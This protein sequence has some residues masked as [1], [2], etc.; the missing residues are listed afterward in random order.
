M[1]SSNNPAPQPSRA[2]V[3]TAVGFGQM[4]AWG[5]SYYLL[6]IIARPMAAGLGLNPVWIYAAFSAALLV[7][8]L[9]G[10]WVGA[11]IDRHGGGKVLLF[12]NAVFAAGLTTLAVSQ[13]PVSMIAGWLLIGAAMPMGLY[14]AAFSTL[15]SL[16]RL[17]ARRS[18][19]GV[20]LIGGFA[21]SVSWP[22]TAALDAHF[23]WRVACAV[24]AVLHLTVGM[25]IHAFLV[26]RVKPVAIHPDATE[27]VQ[28]VAAPSNTTLW[29]LA[30]TF[31]CNGFIFAAMAAHL[32]RVLQ[33]AGCTPTAAVAAAAL[34]GVSQVVARL[35]DAGF[36]HRVHP[37]I[38]GRIAVSLHPLGAFLL[39]VFG[40]PVAVVFTALHGAS[41]GL[42]TIVKGTLPL[43]LF[44]SAGFGR[45]AGLL[46]APSRVVQALAPIAFGLML[47]SWGAHVLWISGAIGCVGFCGLMILRT[48][49]ARPV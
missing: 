30:A 23:G 36:L 2:R 45:R 4:L 32:P 8:A 18:I 46:E 20:T 24:W 6:A 7:A 13:G 41:V 9:L 47:D 14:D 19:V 48:K 10:P 43:A 25:G 33:A 29:I 39:F 17:E 12:S 16:Y 44:G 42:M 34:L 40:A 21:S 49:N 5:S 26:P 15:V 1:T 38:A 37:L 31:T 35:A 22:L 27:T 3:V 11:R 28:P